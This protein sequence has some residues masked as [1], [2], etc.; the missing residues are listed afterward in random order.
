MKKI[1]LFNLKE[2]TIIS[3]CFIVSNFSLAQHKVMNNVSACEMP[4]SNEVYKR[5]VPPSN[6]ILQRLANR[7]TSCS[8]IIVTYNNFPVNPINPSQPGQEQL[9]FQYAVEIWE[10]LLSS[11]V[12]IR[13]EATWE[14]LGSGV[15]GSASSAH[16]AL[17]P[18][19]APNTLYPGALAESLVGSEL[20]GPNSID[21]SCSFNAQFS[22]WYF[23]TDGNPSNSQVD[24]VSVVLHELGHGLGFAGFSFELNDEGYLRRDP[25]GLTVS[26]TSSLPSIWDNFIDTEDIFANTVSLLNETLFPDPSAIML[27]QFESGNLTCNGPIA[28]AQ[29]GGVPP[30]TYAPSTYNSGS[31][32]SHWD[33]ATFNGT[34]S[35][36]MTPFLFFGEA[37]HNPGNVT[38]GFLEDM[39][40]TLCQ[41]TLD[42]EDILVSEITISPNPFTQKIEL[43]L[44]NGFND[45]YRLEIFDINGRI[46][47]SQT[48]TA[49]NGI[50]ELA[51]LDTLEKALYFITIT[52]QESRQSVTK[53]LI[54]N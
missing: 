40:W 33:E 8:N 12:P 26:P 13:I 5:Y 54:K 6:F 23:G 24:F 30:P 44:A 3:I 32:Y 21:I 42:T 45:S 15:L 22:S 39:G 53:K 43:T 31:S 1:T 7:N 28:S 38:L 46:M 16:F 52:N 36:L 37:I 18:G 4:V 34:P 27:S 25:S 51:D 29:N 9:A 17:V 50:I 35:A 41:G 19:G 11:S 20:N 10:C 14:N 49:N 2:L 47:F 48:E